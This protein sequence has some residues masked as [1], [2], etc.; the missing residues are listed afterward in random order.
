M[1]SSRVGKRLVNSENI[2]QVRRRDF[3]IVQT[4]SRGK[5]FRLCSLAPWAECLSAFLLLGPGGP[6]YEFLGELELVSIN[7]AGS[8]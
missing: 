7:L 2:R 4:N 3:T 1:D 6:S 5:L 8:E